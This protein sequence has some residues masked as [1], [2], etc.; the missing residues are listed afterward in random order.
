[1]RSLLKLP[2]TMYHK[3]DQDQLFITLCLSCKPK[4]P[5]HCGYRQ[6]VNMKP[7]CNY[8]SIGKMNKKIPSWLAISKSHARADDDNQYCN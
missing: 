7:N 3:C 6:P 2:S 1:M 8:N 5:G 4:Q